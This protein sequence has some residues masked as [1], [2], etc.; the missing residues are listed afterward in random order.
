MTSLIVC[1]YVS[2]QLIGSSKGHVPGSPN[3]GGDNER[4]RDREGDV[5]TQAEIREI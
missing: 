5:M 1:T 2:G 3:Q 4:S